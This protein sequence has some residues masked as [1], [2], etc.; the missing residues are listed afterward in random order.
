MS[1]RGGVEA[2]DADLLAFIGRGEAAGRDDAAFDALARRVFA[3]Q[4]ELNAPY[5]RLCDAEGVTPDNLQRLI[6]IPACPTDAFKEF[7]LTTFPV[8][9]AAAEY[10]SS[11][12]TA[13]ETSRHWLPRLDLYEAAAWESFRYFMGLEKAKPGEWGCLLLFPRPEAAPHS[14]LGHMLQVVAERLGAPTRWLLPGPDEPSELID[15][16]AAANESGRP[17]LVLGTAFSFVHACDALA[18]ADTTVQL[19]TGSRIMET[20]GYKGRSRTVAKARLHSLIA[21]WMGVPSQYIENEYGMTEM[22]SQAYDGTI[23]H[24]LG[25]PGGRG[26]PTKKAPPWC[27]TWVV[28]PADLSREV[29][30][31]N[32]GILKH[33]DLVN[34]GSVSCLLT[35]DRAT[36]I[37]DGYEVL[38]RAA[39][40]QLRGCSLA[41]EELRGG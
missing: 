5:R 11:G 18:A 27:R 12:T 9:K 40:A 29:E 17:L 32:E 41:L 2:L 33:L 4:Y 19:P 26:L 38:G 35:A 39:G 1:D 22:G 14:S 7:E 24:A 37:G 28:D 36:R 6:D 10:H 20:G 21:E 8:A 34:R 16:V 15:A 23:R 13:A 3:H 25:R 31:S 30:S